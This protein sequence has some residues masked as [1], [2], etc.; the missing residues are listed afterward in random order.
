MNPA[1]QK[2]KS[3]LEVYEQD[4]NNDRPPFLLTFAEVKLLGITGVSTTPYY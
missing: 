4:T 3:S 2:P 1:R